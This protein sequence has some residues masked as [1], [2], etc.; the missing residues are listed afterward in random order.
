MS[1]SADGTADVPEETPKAKSRPP[2]PMPSM[3]PPSSFGPPPGGFRGPPPGIDLSF[4]PRVPP[5]PFLPPM[6]MP[7][8][9]PSQLGFPG[10]VPAPRALDPPGYMLFIPHDVMRNS[11]PWDFRRPYP[12]SMLGIPALPGFRARPLTRD[13]EVQTPKAWVARPAMDQ[14]VGPGGSMARFSD[15]IVQARP[16]NRE[17]IISVPEDLQEEPLDGSPI[18]ECSDEEEAPYHDDMADLWDSQYDREGG[19]PDDQAAEE[20]E[21]HEVTE[22]PAWEE[23]GH[24]GVPPEPAHP[25]MRGPPLMKAGHMWVTPPP[26]AKRPRLQ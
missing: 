26:P 13:A 19:A 25:P 2:M 20:P 23:P 10:V 21:Q 4:P 24:E 14:C 12:E 16:E 15:A 22:S 6:P 17:A 18:R 1:E 8:L 7:S 11:V 3:R 5:L 9:L